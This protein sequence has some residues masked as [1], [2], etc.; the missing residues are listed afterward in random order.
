MKDFPLVETV[1]RGETLRVEVLPHGVHRVVLSRPEVRN[2]FDETM[3][4]ELGSAL[5][6][7]ATIEPSGLRLLLLEGE[8]KVF[9]A[10]A[11]L[12][13]MKRLGAKSY[14]ESLGDARVLARLFYR[15]ADFP[16][17]V[18]AY[19]QGAAIGGGLGLTVCA[20]YV[21]A[22]ERT[23]FAT[24]EVRLGI[25]PGVISPYIVRKIGLHRAA[26]M[27]LSG[28]RIQ[29]AEAL[30]AGLVQLVSNDRA[31]EDVLQE[32]VL[33]FLAAGPEAARRTKALIKRASPLPDSEL[34]EF[35]AVQIAE[36]RAA[37]EGKEGLQSFF[38]KT[39]PPWADAFNA[40]RDRKK[41]GS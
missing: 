18:I 23:V 39:S 37:N 34:I 38:D 19:V 7:L 21:V 35:T 1:H 15:L 4:G 32:V 31:G 16:A 28:R 10:G 2:A 30:D 11:D 14:E 27:M 17:P 3:M 20:D 12:G 41:A 9:S 24:S 13:Y 29:A 5:D 8:G 25:V 40:L 22:E 6:E 36:A 33:D 26:P